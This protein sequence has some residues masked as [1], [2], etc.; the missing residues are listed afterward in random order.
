MMLELRDVD[1]KTVRALIA[2]DVGP[3]QRDLVSPNATTL[4]EAAHEPGSR[5]WGLWNGDVPVG[6][7]AMIHPGETPFL[8]EGDDPEAAYLWRL[9]VDAKHQG[10]GHGRAALDAAV[11]Q[12][13]AWGL[14]RLVATVADEAHSN[15]G[16]Y[17]RFGFRRTGRVVGDEVEIVLDLGQHRA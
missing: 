12:A 8:D 9:M 13:R 5:V 15:I 10:K 7:M 16:F 14:P 2:L 6:L 11:E 4:A 17:E 3:A 1:R